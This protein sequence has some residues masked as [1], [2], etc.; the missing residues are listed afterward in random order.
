VALFTFITKG[1]HTKACGSV[2]MLL[3]LCY[4]RRNKEMRRITPMEHPFHRNMKPREKKFH[5]KSGS[6]KEH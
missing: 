4:E 3:D 6:F 5:V 2:T 1:N